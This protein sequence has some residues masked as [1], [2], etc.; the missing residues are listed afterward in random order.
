MPL[1][2]VNATTPDG[3][4][5]SGTVGAY[6]DI[7]HP[8]LANYINVSQLPSGGWY[9]TDRTRTNRFHLASPEIAF[10]ARIRANGNVSE[11]RKWELG[12]TQ[13]ILALRRVAKYEGGSTWSLRQ[14]PAKLPIR[15]GDDNCMLWYSWDSHS[16]K[17]IKG[18]GL[19]T[20][21][22]EDAPNQDFPWM[23]S[24]AVEDGLDKPGGHKIVSTEGADKFQTYAIV[25][26]EKTKSIT[27][28]GGFE[29]SVLWSGTIVNGVWTPATA[30]MLP[31][32]RLPQ[33]Q[34]NSFSNL[35]E[36]IG[37]RGLLPFNPHEG[38]AFENF[39]IET[40]SGEWENCSSGGR[41]KDVQISPGNW[42]LSEQP[43]ANYV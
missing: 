4:Q 3:I 33:L 11:N 13:N 16:K 23:Y 36:D 5:L 25:A 22:V 28:L 35:K 12:F 8:I 2:E 6:V 42:F 30:Q 31:L 15:D 9:G 40:P 20:V 14:N 39:Q 1:L 43:Y 34:A 41:I 21:F 24:G 32:A 19:T 26:D 10:H 18:N 27:I 7:N 29:W 37:P 38:C 17:P